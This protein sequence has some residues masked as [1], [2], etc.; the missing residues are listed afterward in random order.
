MAGYRNRNLTLDFD[1]LGEGCQVVIRNPKIMSIDELRPTMDVPVDANGRPT[2]MLL[3]TTASNEVLGRLVVSWVVW[4]VDDDSDDP[5]ILPLP[6]DDPTVI[7]RLPMEIVIRL[8]QEL[9]EAT[10]PT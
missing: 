1:E 8:T 4:G 3:A 5:A 2:D 6:K 7:D 9:G 10:N